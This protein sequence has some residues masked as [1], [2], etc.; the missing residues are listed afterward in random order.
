MVHLL[1]DSDAM[2]IYIG[3]PEDRSRAMAEFYR[4]LLELQLYEP[5]GNLCLQ[6]RPPDADYI[7]GKS[8]DGGSKLRLGIGLDGWSDDRPPR[9]PDPEYPQQLH[10]DIVVPDA[11]AAGELVLSRGATLLRDQGDFRTYADPVGHPFCL[12]PGTVDRP[13][14]QRVVF[15][16]YSP[17]SLAGFYE[18]F[19]GVQKRLEDSPAW[20]EL[21]LD[22]DDDLPNLAF[23]HAQFR[24]TR[25]PDPAYP[26]Q[27]HIDYRF[28]DG[29]QA[30][31]HRAERL[32]AIH[33]PPNEVTSQCYADP[34][35]HPF[36]L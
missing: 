27:L 18:G 33:M 2:T 15:D 16:C 1:R 21:D 34:A 25:F 29:A 12:Y 26:A 23:Q 13:E 10:F 7:A 8:T 5:Y 24:A 32:G 28:P 11:E 9:W 22:D 14:L 17:R 6:R 20:V 3:C 4:D 35:G 19:L 36:C 31:I 30:A